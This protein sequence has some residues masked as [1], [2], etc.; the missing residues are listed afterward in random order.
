MT[1]TAHPTSVRRSMG[2]APPSPEPSSETETWSERVYATL[3][4]FLVG[5]ACLAIAVQSYLSGTVMGLG[6][7]N[8]RLQPWVLFLALGLTGVSAGTFA[9]FLEEPPTP[10]PETPKTV[11]PKVVAPR[12]AAPKVAVAPASRAPEWDE[13][14]IVPEARA[15]TPRRSWEAYTLPANEPVAPPATSDYFLD[16]LDE[17]AASLRRKVNSPPVNKEP[18]PEE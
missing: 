13:S 14:T 18:P 2:V 1:A 3:P 16:Q 8:A 9:L 12:A 11:A 17:I 4:L 5:G 15:P 7:G 6:S 10:S